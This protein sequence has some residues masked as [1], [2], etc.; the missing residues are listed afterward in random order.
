MGVVKEI[1]VFYTAKCNYCGRSYSN[2]YDFSITEFDTVGD[3]KEEIE[4]FEWDFI[5]EDHICC[6]RCKQEQIEEEIAN[7]R[8]E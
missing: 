5:N 6:S 4:A 8:Y 3:L 1:E 2:Q 7:S